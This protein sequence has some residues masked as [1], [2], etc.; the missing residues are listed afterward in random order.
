[1][2]YF[3]PLGSIIY[4][5]SSEDFEAS[6]VSNTRCLSQTYRKAGLLS[7]TSW[8]RVPEN[9]ALNPFRSSKLILFLI[10]FRPTVTISSNMGNDPII[11]WVQEQHASRFSRS[12]SRQDYRSHINVIMHC[13]RLFSD[14]AAECSKK[15]TFGRKG[16][17]LV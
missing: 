12:P 7:K 13:H 14:P 8:L 4:F 1:M 2:A 10:I 6:G 11:T 17:Q 3:C 5:N 15:R 9:K 16:A